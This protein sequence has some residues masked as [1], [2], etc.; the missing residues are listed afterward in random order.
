MQERTVRGIQ[1][2]VLL[3]E[4]F[5][6]RI[7]DLNAAKRR[8]DCF[9]EPKPHLRWRGMHFGSDGRIGMFQKGVRDHMR[10][11][12]KC[13]KTDE[14][15]TAD[16]AH[17]F[18]PNK[19]RPKLC[20]KRSSRYKCSCAMKPTSFPVRELIGI[21]A[22]APTWKYLPDQ[23]MP[24]LTVPVISPLCPRSSGSLSETSTNGMRRSNGARRPM[25]RTCSCK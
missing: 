20:E 4:L 6:S 25:F 2:R 7:E 13:E 16:W 3:V 9:R 1:M 12:Q 24:G 8:L 21:T 18:L 15:D 5:P 17:L 23:M 10:N 22:S 14:N 11:R 19:G